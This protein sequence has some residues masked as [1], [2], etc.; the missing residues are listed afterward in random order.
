MS[1][2]DSIRDAIASLLGKQDHQV[3]ND[4]AKP[5]HQNPDGIPDS[6]LNAVKGAG[7]DDTDE[8]DDGP[9]RSDV[10]KLLNIEPSI[11]VPD[12]YLLPGDMDRIQFDVTQPEGYDTKMVDD[13][14]ESVYNT[15]V[16]YTDVMKK[17]NK[18]IA[19]C[20]TQMDKMV[21]DLHNAK[22]N[23]EMS[24]GLTVMTGQQST[25]EVELQQAQLT[26]VKLRDKLS[27]YE[28]NGKPADNAG[29]SRLDDLQNQVSILQSK[30]KRLASEN[31][32]LK[33]HESV[34][35]EDDVRELSDDPLA[36]ALPSD[37][38]LPLPDDDYDVNDNGYKT[39]PRAMAKAADD[40]SSL[41]IDS[42]APKSV[43]RHHKSA[44]SADQSPALPMPDDDDDGLPLPDVMDDSY[45]DIGLPMGG[46]D[47]EIDMAS[48]L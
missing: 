20:G 7:Q 27:Q 15:L 39:S 46:D 6:V 4:D 29:D 21:T 18:D 11:E 8:V 5:G 37:D 24:D 25:A 14:F 23:E 36:D 3:K 30:I 1:I 40:D 41:D 28:K 45:E 19:K 9:E 13:F 17:R 47:D 12:E 44:A 32:R 22:L 35:S 33:L 2:L 48:M 26:I 34:E 10:L 31:K 42:M 43:K 38:A 16:F